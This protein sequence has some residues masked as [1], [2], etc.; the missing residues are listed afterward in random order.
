MSVVR[1]QHCQYQME[2]YLAV[3]PQC[4]QELQAATAIHYIGEGLDGFLTEAAK[5]S[6]PMVKR[7]VALY[8]KMCQGFLCDSE[9]AFISVKT[10]KGP[11]DD[12]TY[13]A[14]ADVV[15]SHFQHLNN[16]ESIL[17]IVETNPELAS[18][19]KTVVSMMH[20]ISDLLE[21]WQVGGFCY[22][23]PAVRQ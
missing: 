2:N 12:R 18:V 13:A 7:K 20:K 21:V 15:Q 8:M 23:R 1:C 11:I 5:I 6:P 22:D 17:K 10:F 19:T 9:L 16:L 3:C 14:V 4:K